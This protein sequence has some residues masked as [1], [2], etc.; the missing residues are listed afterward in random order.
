MKPLP[1]PNNR[2]PTQSL[3]AWGNASTISMGVFTIRAI[4]ALYCLRIVQLLSF[5]SLYTLFDP[6]IVIITLQFVD[7][8]D[9]KSEILSRMKQPS[10]CG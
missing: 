10:L 5:F 1:F 2:A 3:I 7:F 4:G 9:L 6:I 8:D